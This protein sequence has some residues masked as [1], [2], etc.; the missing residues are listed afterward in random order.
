MSTKSAKNV[1]EWRKNTK[2]KLIACMG[3][4]C[5]ICN[6]YKSTNALE[7]HHI[8]PSQKDFGF[9]SIRANP[10]NWGAIKEELE[11]CILLC[12][13]CHREVHDNITKLPEQYQHFDESIL[14]LPE[15]IYLLKAAKTTYC[16]VCNKLKENS[17]I[18][19]SRECANKRTGIIQWDLYDL[20]DMIENQKIPKV[21]IAEQIGCSDAA[22]AKRYKKLKA[23]Q[24]R[25]PTN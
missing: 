1:K 6:Y 16:P 22:V 15:N 19:C 5:Q 14:Q 10:K 25:N 21:V 20:I 13:N 7:F 11:K 24:Q 4:K 18:T 3:S 2:Q 9:A 17:N 12:S 23:V 8:D